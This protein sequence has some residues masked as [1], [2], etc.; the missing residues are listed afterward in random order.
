[1]R[2]DFDGTGASPSGPGTSDKTDAVTPTLEE[3]MSL[4]ELSA[5][6]NNTRR[7]T[8]RGGIG[9]SKNNGAEV[10]QRQNAENVQRGEQ[11]I[12]RR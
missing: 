1:M 3:K 6:R 4:L 8:E 11:K 5:T 12:D 2:F 10:V 7:S 9:I